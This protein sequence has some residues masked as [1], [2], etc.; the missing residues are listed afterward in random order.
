MTKETDVR[1]S[2][3][4][5]VSSSALR[6]ALVLLAVVSS[7]S[8]LSRPT[9]ADI[10]CADIGPR[11]EY[12][13]ARQAA[14][15]L[16]RGRMRERE[17][18]KYEPDRLRQLDQ[19]SAQIVWDSA[20]RRGWYDTASSACFG[21]QLTASVNARNDHAELTGSEPWSFWFRYGALVAMAEPS[22]MGRGGCA[23]ELPRP[24]RLAPESSDSN[25]TSIE[26]VPSR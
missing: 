17:P 20:V 6:L 15:S 16:L 3:R 26:L 4:S 12:E 10:D 8:C 1:P 24:I 13:P 22:R 23:E 5:R 25:P 11:P 2:R 19:S 9:Q 21:W 18:N 14:E 7:S